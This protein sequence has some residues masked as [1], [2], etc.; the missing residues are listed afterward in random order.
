MYLNGLKQQR[1]SAVFCMSLQLLV[2]QDQRYSQLNE[3]QRLICV[4][5]CAS[6]W[7]P[8][9]C[10]KAASKAGT[11]NA[12]M[13][14]R[15]KGLR[16]WLCI[17][18][19]HTMCPYQFSLSESVMSTF[20][21]MNSSLGV[22]KILNS[23]RL[24][25]NNS[26]RQ[27]WILQGCK[28]HGWLCTTGL[29]LA[30][31][32]MIRFHDLNVFE[33]R[34]SQKLSHLQVVVA[35]FCLKSTLSHRLSQF[36]LCKSGSARF[37][38]LRC[39]PFRGADRSRRSKVS[40]PVSASSHKKAAEAHANKQY[41][42][43]KYHVQL[44]CGPYWRWSYVIIISD[45]NGLRFGNHAVKHQRCDTNLIKERVIHSQTPRSFTYV[46][47][48]PTFSMFDLQQWYGNWSIYFRGIHMCWLFFVFIDNY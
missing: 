11:P 7:G 44:G 47:M 9:L 30:P 32:C 41:Q 28:S 17:I 2:G 46:D 18:A 4:A 26:F 39:N 12:S 19:N 43:A 6:V 45:R 13:A 22:L 1:T 14:T 23:S 40:V 35:R 34:L 37:R 25:G 10:L 16:W 20:S 27:R 31:C 15:N 48:F 42:V 3:L 8:G 5:R 21:Q 24:A 33:W 36:W 29:K 38:H